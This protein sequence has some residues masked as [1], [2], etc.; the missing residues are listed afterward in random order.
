MKIEQASLSKRELYFDKLLE[1]K[2]KSTSAKMCMVEPAKA[3]I[4]LTEFLEQ[5]RA[6]EVGDY[7]IL[8]DY[9][10]TWYSSKLHLIEELT[11]RFQKL[12]NNPVQDAVAALDVL[13]RNIGA[14]AIAVGDT[15]IGL[16]TPYYLD[17]GYT[18]LG[19]QLFKEIKYG[20]YSE[21]HRGSGADRRS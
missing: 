7:L 14:R 5:G 21:D 3:F 19:T 8:Y 12:Y 18:T 10:P 20:I 6:V 11:M 2:A 1:L 13:A 9:G 15:Q 16:M 17:A 4:S